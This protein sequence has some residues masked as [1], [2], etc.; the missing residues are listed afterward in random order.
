MAPLGKGTWRFSC[1]SLTQGPAL[2][3]LT[4]LHQPGSMGQV[5]GVTAAG[6]QVHSQLS[7][8]GYINL[9]FALSV[10]EP[11]WPS[12]Q[13]VPTA[14]QL[15]PE[16]SPSYRNVKGLATAF[17]KREHDS[18][19]EWV[20]KSLTLLLTLRA[21]AAHLEPGSSSLGSCAGTGRSAC[22]FWASH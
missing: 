1:C 18:Q 21:D 15:V 13:S 8:G 16:I 19:Q 9:S 12:R 11:G 3:C 14:P 7:A 22:G 2:T 17:F 5:L 4:D 10:A 20:S 6:F